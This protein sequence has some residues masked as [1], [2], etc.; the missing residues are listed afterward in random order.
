MSL[1][2]RLTEDMKDA[3]K[4]KEA[5]KLKLSVI[6]MV[7]AAVK[8]QEIDKGRELNDE[9]VI[10][11]LTREVKLRRDSVLEYE[12]ANRPETVETI[13]K[14]IAIL[15]EY[16]PQQMTEEEVITLVRK[17][18]E[19][20]GAQ[21]PKDMGK[22]MGKVVPL[23]KGKADGKFVNEVVRKILMQVLDSEDGSATSEF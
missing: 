8:N 12:K 4:A 21:S 16:L 17:T 1:K 23:T 22:I 19:E 20:V 10:Q 18:I 7:K 6:R 15:M 2:E 9:E 13:N 3:M 14:E 11:V 5:G